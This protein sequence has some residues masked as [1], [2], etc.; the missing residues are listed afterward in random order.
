MF[1][2]KCGWCQERF[3]DG[4]DLIEV[5]HHFF[6][7]ICAELYRLYCRQIKAAFYN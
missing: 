3:T 7:T 2:T 6:H 4:D 1:R 5:D